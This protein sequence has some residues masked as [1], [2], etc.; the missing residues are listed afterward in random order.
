MSQAKLASL[1]PD[2]TLSNNI[3]HYLNLTGLQAF[4]VLKAFPLT[5]TDAQTESFF[6]AYMGDFAF[7]VSMDYSIK[8]KIYSQTWA[9]INVNIKTA[10]LQ[11]A[12][13]QSDFT[14]STFRNNLLR[15]NFS[16]MS[17]ELKGN[18]NLTNGTAWL[19]SAYLIDSVTS[20]CNKYQSISFLVD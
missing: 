2:P 5:L 20:V 16:A 10:V 9:N 6:Q 14:T 13:M 4:Y 8:R 11:T 19:R 3:A 18:Y 15:N 7:M 17:A 12:K 1:V